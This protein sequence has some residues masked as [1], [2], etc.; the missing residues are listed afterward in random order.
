MRARLAGTLVL[1][2]LVVPAP[3]TAHEA[4]RKGL[5][6][7]ERHRAADLAGVS[8][9]V[10]ERRMRAVTRKLGRQP[11]TRPG[12]ARAAA[13]G[14]PGTVGSWSPVITAPV[15]PIFEALLP[16]RK[17][18]MWD[19]VGD[20]PAESYTDQTFTRAAVYDPATNTSKRVDVAGANLFCAG[21]VQLANG[22]VFVAGGNARQ[23]PP[24]PSADPRVRLAH[25]DLVARPGHA[26]RALVPVGRVH[27]QRRG[28]D[29]RRRPDGGRDPHDERQLRRLT[30]IV[31]PSSREYP[32]FQA[33]A[34]RAAL[35]LGPA[36]GLSLLDTAGLGSIA[37]AG[38]RDAIARS[39]GSYAPFDVG[40]FLV[41]GGGT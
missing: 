36:R 12:A 6:T 1:A 16:N 40:R 5:T 2:A 28:A 26:G 10:F 25:R 35:L 15:V 21:F 19:S 30:G 8:E 18:L 23:R 4:P 7:V 11:G 22:N 32:F 38:D 41:A 37:A 27:A 24:R 3:A 29:H 33:D 20:G 39:Y 31:T 9:R 14:D 17:I 13:V 34:R